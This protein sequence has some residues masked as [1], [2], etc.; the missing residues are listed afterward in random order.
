M[1]DEH[2]AFRGV[3]LRL[4]ADDLVDLDEVAL[5]LTKR[6]AGAKVSRASAAMAAYRRGLEAIR[7]DLAA[8]K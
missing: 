7:G 1:S 3:S 2:L 5:Q 6:A 8:K 4:D